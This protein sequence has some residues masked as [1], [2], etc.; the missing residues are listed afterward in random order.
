MMGVLKH[1]FALWKLKFRKIKVRNIINHRRELVSDLSNPLEGFRQVILV[2]KVYQPIYSR[3]T[4]ELGGI[5]VR[6]YKYSLPILDL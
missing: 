2:Y 6:L 3:L 5:P 1:P 4:E